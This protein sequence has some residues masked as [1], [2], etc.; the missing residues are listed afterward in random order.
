MGHPNREAIDRLAENVIGL[1]AARGI[2]PRTIDCEQ[3]IQSKAHQMI[4]RRSGNEVG[5]TRLFSTL[6]THT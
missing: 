6:G 3:C 2:A 5:A 1:T 4:S